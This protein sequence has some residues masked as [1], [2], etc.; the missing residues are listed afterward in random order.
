MLTLN[1]A[2]A[3]RISGLSPEPAPP[4][5]PVR[6]PRWSWREQRGEQ[7][8]RH[9]PHRAHLG[10]VLSRGPGRA[11]QVDGLLLVLRHMAIGLWGQKDAVT[12]AKLSHGWHGALASSCHIQ[13]HSHLP[14]NLESRITAL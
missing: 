11:L 10:L 9:R 7:R 6:P 14:G 5:S 1:A 12:T 4:L 3:D 8:R 13:M 2:P